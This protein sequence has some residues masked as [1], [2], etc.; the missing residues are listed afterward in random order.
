MTNRRMRPRLPGSAAWPLRTVLP[1]VAVLTTVV[2]V[3]GA[4]HAAAGPPTHTVRYE[5]SGVP[6]ARFAI[7]YVRDGDGT[8]A[9]ALDTPVPWHADAALHRT[10]APFVE[11]RMTV[12]RGAAPMPPTAAST[13]CRIVADGRVVAENHTSARSAF[14]D[15]DAIL[16]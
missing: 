4:G 2:V 9:K 14:V 13:A 10:T 3:T 12:V 6:G 7:S 15:C 5:V 1:L 8:M 11:L 16:N